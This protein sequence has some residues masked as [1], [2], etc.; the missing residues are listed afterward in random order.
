MGNLDGRVCIITGASRGIG[1]EMARRFAADGAVV[2]VTAR[3]A[4]EG[5]HRFAGSVTSTVA[6]IASAGGTALAVPADLSRQED[7]VR[8][9]E[10]VEK[11]LGPVDILVNNAAITYYEPIVEFRESHFRLM[12]EVQVRAPFELAQKVLPGMRERR[13]GWILNISSGAARH[14]AGPPYQTFRSG[15]AVYGMCNA[16]WSASPPVWPPRCTTTG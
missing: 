1:E 2:A 5:D 3:T 12:F 16:A 15:G 4:E 14:P 13:R 6:S 11:E 8:L 7:R 9:V 10:T